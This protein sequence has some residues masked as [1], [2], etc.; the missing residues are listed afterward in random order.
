MQSMAQAVTFQDGRPS[1]P[2]PITQIAFVV[3]NLDSSLAQFHETLG[4]APWH[5][6]EHKPPVLHDTFL[7][8][9][10]ALYSMLGAECH[11][12]P[13]DVELIQ[14]LDGPSIYEEWL[15]EHGEGVHHVA[16]MRPTLAEAEETKEWFVRRGMS[17]LMEGR[18][19]ETI[20]FFYFDTEPTLK[21]IME[22][23]SGHAV[24]MTPIRVFP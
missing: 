14:P 16:V 20:R 7:R 4:W 13:V 15:N 9:K 18:L 2:L 19:G 24:D 11:V 1:G 5:V 6:Y 10:P 23:G 22:S 8:G 12:G 21:V 3:R 17:V